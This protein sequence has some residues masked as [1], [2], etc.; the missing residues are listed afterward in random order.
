MEIRKPLLFKNYRLGID[1]WAILLFLAVMLPNW[2]WFAYPAPNDILR[3]DS[4]TPV[5]DS[6]ASVCQA[7]FLALL[8]FVQNQT[9][10]KIRLS[11][12]L[13]LSLAWYILYLIAWGLY[14]CGI[15]HSVLMILLCIA[16]CF[17]FGSYAMDRKNLPAGIPLLLFTALHFA[18]TLIN[19]VL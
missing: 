8:A 1:P 19:F 9:A 18:S 4:I 5:L 17:A 6:I 11:S 15:L 3:S 7:L 10:P 14:F 2:I 16:P 12:A 13:V